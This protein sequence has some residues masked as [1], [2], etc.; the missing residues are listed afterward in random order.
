VCVCVC[1]CVCVWSLPKPWSW[2][3]LAEASSSLGSLAADFMIPLSHCIFLILEDLPDTI[4]IIIIIVI[5]I[6]I[7]I[8]IIIIIIILY[9][10]RSPG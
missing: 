10:K 9:C 2:C 5:V 4:I 7:V 8:I 6:V 1:V 3:H